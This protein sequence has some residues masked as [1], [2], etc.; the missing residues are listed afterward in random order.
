[1]TSVWTGFSPAYLYQIIHNSQGDLEKPR[2]TARSSR[3][4]S[5]RIVSPVA[6]KSVEKTESNHETRVKIRILAG[7]SYEALI[8]SI[9]TIIFVLN[10]EQRY[11][12]PCDSQVLSDRQRT[13]VVQLRRQIQKRRKYLYKFRGTVV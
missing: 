12:T 4:A 5:S 11:L 10:F 1:M 6:R 7:R 8:C 2:I 13:R 3:F 9:G